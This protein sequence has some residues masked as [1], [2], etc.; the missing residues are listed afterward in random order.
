GTLVRA[1]HYLTR[2][3]ELD[4]R[5]V[6]AHYNLGAAL[7][8]LGEFE[9]AEQATRRALQLLPASSPQRRAVANQLG[10]CPRLRQETRAGPRASTRRDGTLAGLRREQCQEVALTAGT[11]YVIELDGRQFAPALRL[12]DDR[13]K[14]LMENEGHEARLIR[15]VRL[16]VTAP[17]TGPY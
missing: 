11:T 2:A 5:L 9:S 3:T 6:P 15:S 16:L 1:V 12:E 14:V 7:L 17:H 13:G 4:P 10:R 8:D